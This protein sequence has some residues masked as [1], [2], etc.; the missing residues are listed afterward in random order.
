MF[1]A[2][3][4]SLRSRP[5]VGIV[6]TNAGNFYLALWN[7]FFSY[8]PSYF[9]RGFILKKM[10]GMDMGRNVNIHMGVKFLKPW[11]VVIKDDVNVQMGCFI[12]GRGGVHIGSNTDVTI[13]VKILSQQHDID[14]G[15][16][17]TVSKSVHI[18][19]GCVIGSYALIMPG[20]NIA[21]GGVVG[22]GSVVVKS[23]GPWEMVAGNPAIVKRKRQETINYKIGFRRFFH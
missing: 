1:F 21:S 19:E 10:Y 20:V 9:I 16:Y 23:V 17:T 15:D 3:L 12:D 6:I 8:V 11:G 13:G 22:A 14:D 18:G 2:R 7:W 5:L 4:E